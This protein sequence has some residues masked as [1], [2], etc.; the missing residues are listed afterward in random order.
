MINFNLYIND[1]KSEQL[2]DAVFD[3]LNQ[4]NFNIKNYR[5]QS[6]D[7]F[8]NMSG[9]Y[10]GLQVRIKEVIPLVIYVLCSAHSL[11]LVDISSVDC[12]EKLTT[13]IF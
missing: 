7:S 2:A 13:Y 6:Y 10:T 1:S 5:R 11:N 3:T 8:S 12:Y 9:I 4:Y